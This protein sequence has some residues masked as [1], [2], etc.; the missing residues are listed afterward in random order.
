M[1]FINDTFVQRFSQVRLPYV[2]PFFVNKEVV[3]VDLS[4]MP[5]PDDSTKDQFYHNLYLQ[6]MSNEYLDH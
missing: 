3:K 1:I 5:M 2:S 4:S 6:I